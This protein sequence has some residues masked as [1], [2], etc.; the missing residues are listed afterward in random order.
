MHSLGA[1]VRCIHP[2]ANVVQILQNLIA[3][4]AI[5]FSNEV[6][7][8]RTALA[9]FAEAAPQRAGSANHCEARTHACVDRARSVGLPRRSNRGTSTLR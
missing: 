8:L 9:L 2:F 5:L 7:R 6:R 4:G 1:D 3:P